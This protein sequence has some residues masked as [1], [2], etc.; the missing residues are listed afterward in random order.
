MH[1]HR[2]QFVG[3]KVE[4]A[5]PTNMTRKP[6]AKRVKASAQSNVTTVRMCPPGP[7]SGNSHSQ[8]SLGCSQSEDHLC[9]CK[10]GQCQRLEALE[11]LD[12]VVAQ[13]EAKV[14]SQARFWA[15][16]VSMCSL[17]DPATAKG[18][19]QVTSPLVTPHSATA[20]SRY[21]GQ[22]RR[23]AASKSRV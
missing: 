4:R 19:W 16:P 20:T 18:F 22:R 8:G 3:R 14:A 10:V 17:A 15:G 21:G 6:K 9:I 2:R 1:A 12:R 5:A 11:S 7:G 23:A 13:C